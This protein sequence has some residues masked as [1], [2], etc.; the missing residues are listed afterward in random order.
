[1]ST[2]IL[3]LDWFDLVVQLAVT[4]LL[5]V[6]VDTYFVGPQKDIGIGMV[7]TGS[8]AVLG[9]RRRRVMSQDVPSPDRLAEIESRLADLE[10][11]QARL[12]EL[13][14]RVDFAERLLT[15]HSER[16]APPLGSARLGD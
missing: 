8:L 16:A 6:A 1:V 15:R 12:L 14:E 4:V 13:E 11:Q 2:R 10:M 7:I 3:G 9:W 5:G